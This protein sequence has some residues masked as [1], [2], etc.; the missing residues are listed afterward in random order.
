MDSLKFF[1][2]SSE[3]IPESIRKN[4]LIENLIENILRAANLRGFLG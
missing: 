2:P 1:N 3:F 4:N